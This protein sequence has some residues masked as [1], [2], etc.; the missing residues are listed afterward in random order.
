[1]KVFT[2]L[3]FSAVTLSKK[4]HPVIKSAPVLIPGDCG[5][6]GGPPVEGSGG[7]AGN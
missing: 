3:P 5:Q 2:A 7:L 1:M 6:P 4:V